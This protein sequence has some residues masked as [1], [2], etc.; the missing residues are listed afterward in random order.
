MKP[1]LNP[2]KVVVITGAG[3]SAESGI[4]TFR[5][6]NGLW[7]AHDVEAIASATGWAN[8]PGAVLDFT[9][10]LRLR[11]S[12]S[13]PNAAHLAI[14]HLQDRYEVIVIT[15]NVDE[16]HEMAGSNQVLHVHGNHADARSSIDTTLTYRIGGRP[17]L[18]GDT[19]EL[20]S[21]L[22][23]DL[24]LFGEPAQHL[25]EARQHVR[26]ASKIMIV[27]TSLMVQPFASLAKLA[28]G[29]AEKVLISKA[30]Y[31]HLWGY[32]LRTG[33]ATEVVPRVV[34]QWLQK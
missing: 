28:R 18:M 14:A 10:Q 22:R 30:I 24:V 20:G 13:Q 17:I 26:S 3:V 7:H 5:D 6:S 21:Q 23:P 4:P 27:G 29:H 33:L 16:L 9:N 31:R 12:Q 8:N 25:D 11:A 19:C 2:N 1:E 34:E 32:E 15:Q